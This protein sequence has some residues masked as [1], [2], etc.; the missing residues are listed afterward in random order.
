VKPL[1]EVIS[2]F[3]PLFVP[4]LNQLE[5]TKSMWESRIE[6][7]EINLC[8]KKKYNIVDKINFLSFNKK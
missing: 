5:K 4:S 1:M 6:E 3:L 2:N 8:K 7:Y